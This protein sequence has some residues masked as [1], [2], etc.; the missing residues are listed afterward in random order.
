MPRTDQ[1]TR[2]S[3]TV[4]HV[5]RRAVIGAAG[6]ID[7]ATGHLLDEAIDDAVRDGALE[8]WIDLGATRFMDSTGLNVLLAAS[9]RVGGL[10]RR[11]AIVCPRGQVRRVFEIAGLDTALPVHATLASVQRQA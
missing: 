7:T 4:K 6:E 1:P 9:R 10:R 11:L 5:G 8:I 3:L 2:L